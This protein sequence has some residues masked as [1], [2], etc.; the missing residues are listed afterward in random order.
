[1][2][3]IAKKRFGHRAVLLRLEGW[4]MG[5]WVDDLRLTCDQILRAGGRLTLDTR[6]VSFVDERG[7]A[8]LEGLDSRRVDFL[9]T[10]VESG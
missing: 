1:M 8:L 10:L 9:P 6:Q 3:R 4:V 2:L 7:F 5:P